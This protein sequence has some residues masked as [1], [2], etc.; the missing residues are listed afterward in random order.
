MCDFILKLC[1]YSQGYA[2]QA[3]LQGTTSGE[4]KGFLLPGDMLAADRLQMVKGPV[5]KRA[6]VSGQVAVGPLGTDQAP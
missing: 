1:H 6:G 5:G 2:Y 4:P 3:P